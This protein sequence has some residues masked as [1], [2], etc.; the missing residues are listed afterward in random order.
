MTVTYDL[1]TDIGKV[2]L[3]TG[4]KIISTPVFTDE[5]LQVFLTDAGSVNLASAMLL[6]A[7][8]ASYGANADSERIGDYTYTQR[9]VD[10]MLDLAKRLRDKESDAPALAWAEM[11]LTD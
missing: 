8:A 4:D 9:I 7:W 11:D 5:E 10:K 2:R 3:I 6:E 1:A